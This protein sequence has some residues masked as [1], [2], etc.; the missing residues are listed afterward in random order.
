[1]FA[2]LLI[3]W[4][5]VSAPGGHK[6]VFDSEETHTISAQRLLGG[7]KIRVAPGGHVSVID[8]RGRPRWSVKLGH[9]VQHL[10]YDDSDVFLSVGTYVRAFRGGV[11]RWSLDMG[12]IPESLTLS[13]SHSGRE[14]LHVTLPSGTLFI[15][16]GRGKFCTFREPCLGL[17]AWNA[18]E[19]GLPYLDLAGLSMPGVGLLVNL[20]AL[21]QGDFLQALVSPGVLE[22]WESSS[23]VPPAPLAPEAGEL[24]AVST[25]NSSIQIA[26]PGGQYIE[27]RRDRSGKVRGIHIGTNPL[28]P[29]E[30]PSENREY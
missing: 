5:L 29:G 24:P 26:P 27:Y 22:G 10:A 2:A 1:M 13:P 21:G 28:S 12:D 18:G 30:P 25:T 8:M 3:S 16:P 15:D 7:A 11:A 9:E 4:T 23:M 20:G 19:V 17:P 14:Y 6:P